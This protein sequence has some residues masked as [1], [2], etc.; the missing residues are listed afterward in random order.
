MLIRDYS[1]I[2][3]QRD[4]FRQW[5]IIGQANDI[6]AG[7]RPARIYPIVAK[8]DPDTSQLVR[9]PRGECRGWITSDERRAYFRMDYYKRGEKGEMHS[10]ATAV[11]TLCVELRRH[12]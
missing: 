12:D 4:K 11:D 5:T 3:L 8:I 9:I 2:V 7:T 10:E 1:V 6:P